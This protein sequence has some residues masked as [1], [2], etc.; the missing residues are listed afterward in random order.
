LE[1]KL[2]NVSRERRRSVEADPDPRRKQILK[3]FFYDSCATFP[4]KQKKKKEEKEK[5][6]QTKQTVVSG[7]KSCSKV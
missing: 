2:F 6:L 5:G 7:H 4:F 1:K 3:L